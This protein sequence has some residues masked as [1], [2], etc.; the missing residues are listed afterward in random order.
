MLMQATYQ[1]T[2]EFATLT[3]D[4]VGMNFPRPDLRD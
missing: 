1:Q 2:K 3:A 4:K